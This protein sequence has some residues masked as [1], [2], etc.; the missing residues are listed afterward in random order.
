MDI[1]TDF[2]PVPANLTF[3]QGVQL[4]EKEAARNGT[5]MKASSAQAEAAKGQQSKNEA[6]DSEDPLC[7][8]R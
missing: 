3:A 1:F 2:R 8:N 5:A 6:N 4:V 7:C